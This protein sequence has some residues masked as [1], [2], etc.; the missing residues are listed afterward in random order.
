MKQPWL[1]N[2]QK[3][4]N[5]HSFTRSLVYSSTLLMLAFNLSAKPVLT[6]SKY[7]IAT[8][9]DNATGTVSPGTTNYPLV[10]YPGRTPESALET[11]YWIIEEQGNDRYSFRNAST[12]K[13]IR[14]DDASGA[15]RTALVLTDGLAS[16]QS[17]LFTL[18]LKRSGSLSYYIIRT[19]NNPN[20][21]WDRRTTSYNSLYPVGVYD[22]TGSNNE[23]FI[24]Y[25]SDGN[26]AVDDSP[27]AALLPNIGKTLGAFRDYADSILFDSK[28][29]AVD[30]QKKEFY[31]SVEESKIGKSLS[32]NVRFKLK[33]TAHKLFIANKQLV[34]GEKFDFG[35]ASAT[36]GM[37][38]EIRNGAAVIASGKL[39]FTC[40]PLVQIYAESTIGSVYDLSKLSVTEPEKPDSAEV[41]YMNIKTRG[42]YASGFPKKAYAIKL[43]EADGA[44][45]MDRSFFGLRDDNNWILDAM[46]VDTVRMRNRVST[47]LWNDFA[48]K[49]Y[50][51]E[52]EPKLINGT[53][54]R[55]VEVFLNDSYHGLYCMTE[56]L[57]RKQ[58]KLKKLET[59]G[60][61]P[62]VTQR[63]GLY[64]GST[65]ASGTFFG[66]LIWD[67][68]SHTM[69]TIYSNNSET[70]S[71]FEVKYPDLGDGEP[72]N[73]KPLVDALKVSSYL[74][75]DA[76]F[77]SKVALYFDLP[78]F[79]DYYLFIEL[80]L[81]S[82]NQGKNT[83]LSVYNQQ[84]S[85]MLTVS[86]WDLDG[87]WGRRWD[88]S[89]SLTGPEQ[90][91]D[92]FIS[93]H[94]HAQNNLFLRLKRLNY[95]NYN[96]RLKD[97]YRELR[98]SWFSHEK[99]MKRFERYYELFVI[100]GA[101]ARERDRWPVG[102]FA[103]EMQFLSTWIRK[104]LAYL[105]NQY[106]GAPYTSVGN[107]IRPDI[108]LHPNPVRN[109]LTV[110]N[111]A[112][113]DNIQLVTLQGR[114]VT[115]VQATGAEASVDMSRYA[116]G[117]YLVKTGGRVA[118]IV[119][120]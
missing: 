54:G 69:P 59:S 82:D 65:W 99:L 40:L 33:N 38:M 81:A 3:H 92:A 61:P 28:T 117:V 1:T 42:A 115:L 90:D 79:L 66:N 11:D 102:D 43:K 23:C 104:R 75:N 14:Y 48:V 67:N 110:S 111:L 95:N 56:K 89:S 51:Y 20:K 106:L 70:W 22:G 60:N 37:T 116:P 108:A 118:K 31:L 32:M 103:G 86:P 113:G 73:W 2:T 91:F 21:V 16:D 7:L 71:G 105:D 120:N 35:T 24:F 72:V 62:G 98:G 4:V 80:I 119:K 29:P 77:G 18:E 114:V 12:Q 63:G 88:G 5:E 109:S 15:D 112:T 39:Y 84:E 27:A 78:V 76:V 68:S 17:S 53:R 34:S 36:D 96:D 100:S 50:F 10:Y 83:Y 94:E 6:K 55:F 93:T 97:R 58:L 9:S 87:T 13:Y 46:Y 44:T 19:V 64:K 57:D 52:S 30:T 8:L 41:V 49:P 85:P 47:D 26:P 107:K 101:A 25:D 45:A 74:T